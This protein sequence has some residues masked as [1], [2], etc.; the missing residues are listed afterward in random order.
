MTPS[1]ALAVNAET[2]EPLSAEPDEKN[3]SRGGR[4][5]RKL[6]MLAAVVVAVA[7]AYWAFG[8]R[9][10][11]EYFASQENGLREYQAAHPIATA[12]IAIAVYVIVAGFSLPGATVMTLAY[13]WFFGFVIGFVIVSFG[14]TGGATLAFI[15]TRYL[16]RDWVQDRFADRLQTINDAF[17]REG[18]FYLFTLRLIP[19]VPFFLINALMGLT[20]IRV[21]TFWWVSQLGMMPATAAYVYAGASVPSLETLANEGVGNVLSWQLIVAFIAIGLLPLLLKRVVILVKQK[22]TQTDESIPGGA[23]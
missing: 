16:F 18:P 2:P 8:D 10:S 17:E 13:G 23:R 7:V 15:M 19:A 4:L 5:P 1:K 11:F 12:L 6:G 22:R 21:V 20:K 9:L 14:S 3:R